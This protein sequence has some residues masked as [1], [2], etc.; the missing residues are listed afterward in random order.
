M[1]FIT[2]NPGSIFI[3][4]PANELFFFFFYSKEY[5]YNFQNSKITLSTNFQKIFKLKTLFKSN[6]LF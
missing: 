5:I 2:A 6:L 1:E 3:K 4:Q